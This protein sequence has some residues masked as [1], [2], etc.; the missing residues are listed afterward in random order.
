MGRYKEALKRLGM[1]IEPLCKKY[2]KRRAYFYFDA[3]ACY[4]RYG[5]TPN[6][7]IGFGLY[8]KSHIERRQFYTARHSKKYDKHF[9]SPEFSKVFWNKEKF[10]EC[11]CDY[12]K[13]GW[14]YVPNVSEEEF[15]TF[16]QRY[17]NVI[18]KHRAGSSGVGIHKYRGESYEKLKN[19]QALIEEFIVQHEKMSLLNP[20]SVNTVRIYTCLDKELKPHLVSC[21]VRVG[22]KNS[23]VDNYHSG[24]IAYPLDADTGVVCGAG[25][26]IMGNEY[27]YHPATGEKAIG[28]T[29]PNWQELKKFVFGACQVVKEARLIA[30]DVA[31]LSDGFDMIEANYDGDPGLMQSPHKQGKLNEIKRHY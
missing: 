14:I 22:G 11:F 7:Y 24:G 23:D 16:I 2:G 20:S 15:E 6:E 30:W 10:N 8:A 13:R 26:D 18:V 4:I 27:L 3:L 5:V 25:Y 19:S 29:I 21:I 9:N 12:V 17:P 31:V 1:A 28:F